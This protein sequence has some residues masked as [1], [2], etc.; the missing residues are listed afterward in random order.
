KG[1]SQTEQSG[2]IVVVEQRRPSQP[3]LRE[4]CAPVQQEPGR[5]CV[6]PIES[7]AMRMDVGSDRGVDRLRQT[8]GAGAVPAEG[9]GMV[10][11]ER[12]PVFGSYRVIDLQRWNG[13]GSL[14]SI[15]L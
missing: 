9:S 7:F 13:G 10:P 6:I 14:A 12:Q 2:R 1:S 8:D 3:V 15:G 5:D 4:A 11:E